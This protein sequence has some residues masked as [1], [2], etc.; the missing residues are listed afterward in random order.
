[1]KCE[2]CGHSLVSARGITL[3]PN[4]INHPVTQATINRKARREA[5]L[6]YKIAQMTP[7]EKRYFDIHYKY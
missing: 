4:A 6:A 7:E 2:I 1:M 3:C 5:R